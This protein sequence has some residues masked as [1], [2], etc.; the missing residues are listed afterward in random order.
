MYI[1]KPSWLRH[2][3]KSSIAHHAPAFFVATAADSN[4]PPQESR[5]ISRSIAATFRPMA[6]GWPPP[7]EVRRCDQAPRLVDL[8]LN[9]NRWPCPRLVDRSHLQRRPSRLRQAS[10]ALPHEPPPGHHP[11]GALLPE[12]ALPRIRRRRP[13]HLHL[14][15]RQQ[16]ALTRRDVWYG[17]QE[18]KG[19]ISGHWLTIL[20]GQTNPRR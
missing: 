15:T 9:R 4:C 11:L 20:Q 10:T 18:Q 7:A 5:K 14:P 16:P 1:I 3:G 19:P 12:R 13:S 2:S 17:P 6:R 8:L